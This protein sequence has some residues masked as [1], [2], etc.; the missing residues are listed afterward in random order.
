MK[1]A[2]L[3]WG[4]FSVSRGGQ[5]RG[6]RS[7]QT[8]DAEGSNPFRS[9]I[10][11][12][13]RVSAAGLARKSEKGKSL[14]RT[15]PLRRRRRPTRGLQMASVNVTAIDLKPQPRNLADR[16]IQGDVLAL[17]VEFIKQFDFVWG[18]P[19][20]QAHTA[21]RHAHN[22]RRH[23]DLIGETRELLVASDQPFMIE[24]VPGA[25]L[26]SPS[27][28][29]G[30]SFGLVTP[31][32]AELRRHRIFECNFPVSTLPCRH[33]LGRR[34]HGCL[35]RPFWEP[36]APDRNRPSTRNGLHRRRRSRRDGHRRADDRRL[37]QPAGPAGLRRVHCQ[38]VDP[39]LGAA[40]PRTLED[41]EKYSPWNAGPRR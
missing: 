16:F 25:P 24:N 31:C 2:A 30:S 32:V 4:G 20:C 11:A 13:Q 27:L 7:L 15:R 39:D 22:A 10:I 8:T 14:A 17:P 3:C 19:P 9:T 41:R 34:G 35:R 33:G 40:K 37:A 28:L 29:C 26:R 18:S 23:E 6:V 1:K 38:A 21:L 12:S 36:P 5:V